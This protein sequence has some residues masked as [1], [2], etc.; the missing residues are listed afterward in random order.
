MSRPQTD[1]AR[2]QPKPHGRVAARRRRRT[3]GPPP[4]VRTSHEHTIFNLRL[5]FCSEMMGCFRIV[6]FFFFFFCFVATPSAAAVVP[7][8]T[9]IQRLFV[10]SFN[11]YRVVR[12]FRSG[13]C[14]CANAT[15]LST[16]AQYW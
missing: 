7:T 11:R 9:M 6:G 1:A 2:R 12:S 3:P 5:G 14:F 8:G 15:G 16:R 13:V 4:L 10:R